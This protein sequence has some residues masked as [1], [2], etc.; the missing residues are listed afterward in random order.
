MEKKFLPIG[1]QYFDVMIEG[2]YVYVDKTKQIFDLARRIGG[3]YFL[4]RP[5]RFGKSLVVSTLKELFEG[6]KHLFEGLWIHDKWDWTKKYPVIHLSFD[7]MGYKNIGLDKA[8]EHELN[9]IA[10]KHD[11]VL[12]A[13]NYEYQFRELIESLY[14]KKGKVVLLIDEYD[15]P[16]I[17][18]LETSK[19]PQA[20]INQTIMKNFYSILKN[21]SN[22]IRCLFITGVS[23]FSKVSIFSDLNHL[24]DLT[25]DKDFATLVG[26]TQQELEFYFADYI[27]EAA[28]GLGLSR[29][30]LLENMRVW[31]DGFSWDGK[32]KLYNPFGVINFL[33]KQAFRNYWFSSGTPTFLLQ[34]MTKHN[35][36][37]I[38]NSHIKSAILEKYNISNLDLI[39]LLF[40][41]GYLTVKE[42]NPLTDEM[43]LDYPNREVRES[44]YQFMI[45]GMTNAT[46]RAYY[47]EDSLKSLLDAF[48]TANLTKVKEVINQLLAGLPS[49]AYDIKSEGLYHGLLHFIFKLLGIYIKSEVHSSKGRADS[50]VET[51]THVFIF[52]FKFNRTAKEAMKQIKTNG[53][54]NPYWA[55]GKKII[56]IGANF[57]SK[58]KEI[59]GWV[60]ETLLPPSV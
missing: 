35:Q 44:M 29:E 4:S 33:K 14:Q 1:I 56:G 46:D 9:Q 58:N 16:I 13:T 10:Q 32:N 60:E 7:V 43:V 51:P 17:D 6:K 15:K 41:T 18:F 5:R 38:E 26:Y 55:S 20:E 45:N 50:I 59:R 52:E 12:T 39:P 19:L 48:A 42:L 23:K 36:F 25:I 22:E 24:D 57:V 21:K 34:Q 49:E 2:N 53:Y 11:I 40:Q 30:D 31:Y 54:A 8:I 3:A 37:A 28:T 27:E 47:A